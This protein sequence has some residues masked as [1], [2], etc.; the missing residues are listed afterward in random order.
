MVAAWKVITFGSF[1]YNPKSH[2]LLRII[3]L[4]RNDVL[5]ASMYNNNNIMMLGAQYTIL[6]VIGMSPLKYYITIVV[7]PSAAHVKEL[8]F[9][10]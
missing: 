5:G 3:I 6:P 7:L 8:F 10:K 4:Y 1:M 2:L 9:Y